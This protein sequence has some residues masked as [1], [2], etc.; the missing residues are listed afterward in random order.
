MRHRSPALF[1][2]YSLTPEEAEAEARAAA[3]PLILD[4]PAE[5]VAKET[6][7]EFTAEF[8]AEEPVEIEAPTA[9]FSP[10]SLELDEDEDEDDLMAELGMIEPEALKLRALEEDQLE[11]LTRTAA[12]PEVEAE[13]AELDEEE[14][15]EDAFHD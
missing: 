9:A 13:T 15:E 7:E 8:D 4:T 14:P 11:A 6:A 10:V 2:T 1:E 5:E 12:A 3:A